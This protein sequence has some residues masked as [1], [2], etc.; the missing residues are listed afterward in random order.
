MNAKKR[1]AHTHASR[2]PQKFGHWDD[3]LDLTEARPELK[4]LT[5]RLHFDLKEGMIWLG[6][7]RMLLLQKEWFADLREELCTLL[8]HQQARGLLTRLGYAAGCRDATVALDLYGPNASRDLIFTGGRLHAL[9]GMVAPM[10]LMIDI[11]PNGGH[12]HAEFI[13][14]NSIEGQ[15]HVD[16]HSIGTDSV[17]WMEVGYASGFITT[18]LGTP[19]LVRE[20]ECR[21]R[22]HACC[23]GIARFAHEWE[24]AEEDMKFMTALPR[25]APRE[26]PATSARHEEERPADATGG[27]GQAGTRG[28]SVIGRS[29]AFNAVLHQVNQVADTNATVLLLGESGV[30]KSAFAREVHLSSR[31]ADFPF[32]E[33]NCAA[34]PE[35]LLESELFGVEKGAYTGASASRPGRFEAAEGGTLFLDEIGTLSLSAQGKLLRVL[36]SGEFERLGSS[37]SLRANVRLVTATNEDLE[38]AVKAGRFRLDLYYR[39][40]VFPIHVPPLRERKEDLPALI[41]HFTAIYEQRHTRQVA[42]LTPRA[43]RALLVHDWPGNI[44][45]LENILERA[46]I[47]CPK[48]EPI[49]ISHLFSSN[50]SPKGKGLQWLSELGTLIGGE[51][52]NEQSTNGQDGNWAK[53]ALEGQSETLDGMERRLIE[54]AIEAADNNVARAAKRLGVT[55]ARLDYRLKKW[56]EEDSRL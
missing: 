52:D 31:R 7:Q 8:G 16:R 40:N 9:H 56:R 28:S 33:V 51:N 10:P 45:E 44:R 4:N 22:G 47:L 41:S 23:R 21:A 18:C 5:E 14:K 39:L 3:G 32:I 36:Q 55:R 13:W 19:V 29:A 46:V 27:Y 53:E 12:L 48:G 50:H 34:M 6:T 30:G 25:I 42:G 15:S 26:T 11:D 17:C 38:G 24:D 43:Y 1:S 49:D 54:A 35:S 37:R 2:D 20:I